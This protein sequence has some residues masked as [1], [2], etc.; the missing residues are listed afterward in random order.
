VSTRN[1]FMTTGGPRYSTEIVAPSS[2][3]IL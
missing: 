3:E 1:T 2:S